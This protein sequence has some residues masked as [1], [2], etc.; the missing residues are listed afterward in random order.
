MEIN[1]L[2]FA[3]YAALELRNAIERLL[4]EYLI[5]PHGKEN[6]S[7]KM[8]KAYRAVDLKKMI[9]EVEPELEQKI[10]FMNLAIC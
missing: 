1:P 10:G 7:K 3:L 5:I 4:F 6:I 2:Q 9:E 8:E